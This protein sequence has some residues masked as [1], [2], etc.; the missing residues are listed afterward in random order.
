[1]RIKT[2]AVRCT[3]RANISLKC[4]VTICRFDMAVVMCT[5]QSTRLDKESTRGEPTA[6]TVRARLA[7][8]RTSPHLPIRP[9]GKK[10]RSVSANLDGD[11]GGRYPSVAAQEST[12]FGERVREAGSADDASP[13]RQVPLGSWVQ[14]LVVGQTCRRDFRNGPLEHRVG[15]CER[16]RNALKHIPMLNRA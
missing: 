1:M 4:S 8:R 9:L 11:G 14:L 5:T 13:D 7:R 12:S 15:V 2:H 3:A 10:V 16:G 6:S